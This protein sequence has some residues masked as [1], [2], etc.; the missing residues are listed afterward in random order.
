LKTKD[1]TPFEAFVNC[2]TG[3][4]IMQ[5]AAAAMCMELFPC[6]A[7]QISSWFNCSS[8]SCIAH[9]KGLNRPP[10]QSSQMSHRT[11]FPLNGQMTIRC[12]SRMESYNKIRR[13]KMGQFDG[14]QKHIPGSSAIS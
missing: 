13:R 10:L 1:L 5:M 9:P 8:D 2:Q 4:K 7:F 6:S 11:L 12:A 14:K 3:G